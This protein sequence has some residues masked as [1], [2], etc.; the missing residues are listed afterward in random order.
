MMTWAT[1]YI[2]ALRAGAIV[3]FRPRGGSMRGEIESGDLVEVAPLA[4]DPEPSDIVLCRVNGRQYLHLVKAVGPRGFLIG[5]NRG[6]INGWTSRANIFGIVT[7]V[8]PPQR[9]A[10]DAG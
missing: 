8:N 5:N 2:E 10:D 1:A 4:R 9:M 6:G 7:A 3:R